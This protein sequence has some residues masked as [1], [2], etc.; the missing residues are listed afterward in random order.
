[1]CVISLASA[2][3]AVQ[4]PFQETW[5]KIFPDVATWQFNGYLPCIQYIFQN[6]EKD[7]GFGYFWERNRSICRMNK[8]DNNGLYKKNA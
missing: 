1:M 8:H 5:R 6:I 4:K 2:I 3:H 7:M